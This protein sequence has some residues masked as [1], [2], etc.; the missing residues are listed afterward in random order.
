VERLR[1]DDDTAFTLADD[2][3]TIHRIVRTVTAER[4]RAT[5]LDQWSALEVIG[6]LADAAEI[7]A[8]RVQACVERDR[9][10][11]A[12]YDQDEL[13]A[14][15]RNNERDPMELARR[16]D[17]GHHRIVE[18][19]MKSENRSRPAV[20]SAWGQVDAGHFGAYQ[21]DHSRGHVTALA[22]LFPP[23]N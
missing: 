16:L 1:F 14:A 15:R 19:L 21:A 10:A 17:A 7:F 12:S 13:A 18:L 20:H 6:H 5:K 11:I 8:D 4:L 22:A 3:A 23:A 2:A 9:P